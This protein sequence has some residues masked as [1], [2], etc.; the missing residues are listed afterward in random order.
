M[1]FLKTLAAQS[2]SCSIVPR[3]RLRRRRSSS[4]SFRDEHFSKWNRLCAKDGYPVLIMPRCLYH[5]KRLEKKREKPDIQSQLVKVFSIVFSFLQLNSF[6][7]FE[8][9]FLF[10]IT[11][12]F[13]L[14]SFFKVVHYVFLLCSR[15][16]LSSMMQNDQVS[17]EKRSA[18]ARA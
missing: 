3:V 8:K 18:P 5:Q 6:F 16:Y 15:L 11:E 13:L 17:T 7:L 14:F 4:S 10:L 9:V 1:T 2:I 12:T